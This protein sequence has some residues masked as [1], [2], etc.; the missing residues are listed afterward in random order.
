LK[1]GKLYAID[2]TNTSIVYSYT[3][4]AWS[5]G[6]RPCG[7]AIRNIGNTPR[8]FFSRNGFNTSTTGIY[9]IDL[10]PNGSFGSNQINEI[11]ISSQTDNDDPI[12]DIAFNKDFTE[13]L[14]AQKSN[15]D[16]NGGGG[17]IN[18][19]NHNSVNNIFRYAHTSTINKFK[20]N[21]SG[22]NSGNNW[23]NQNSNFKIGDYYHKSN[24]AGG[25]D[26]SDFEIN[27][28]KQTKCNATIY[29][30]TDL[31]FANPT[32]PS[33]PPT[34]NWTYCYGFTGFPNQH[35][36]GTHNG[37]NVDS[38]NS[39]T[40]WTKSV[41]GDIEIVDTTFN[42]EITPNCQCGDWGSIGFT[43]AGKTNKF[44]CSQGS[45][46]EMQANQ[47][48]ILTLNP[49]YNCNGSGTENCNAVIK[50]D[51]FY[52]DGTSQIGLTSFSGI[53]LEKCGRIRVVMRPTCNG[54]TC[55]PCEFFINVNCCNCKLDI[56][57]IIYFANATGTQDSIKLNCGKTYNNILDCFKNYTIKI[58]SPCG[59]TCEPDEVI[60]TITLPNGTVQTATGLSI[61]LSIGS[62]IGT[63]T[64]TIKVKCN[65]KWCADCVIKFNQTKSCQPVC[66]NCRD[67]VKA[68]FNKDKSNVIVN[69]HPL[70]SQLTAALQLDGGTDVYTQIRVSVIDFQVSSKEKTCLQCYNK[71]NNWGSILSGLISTSGFTAISTNYSGILTNN[72]N[73]NSREIVFNAATPVSVAAG[74]S[75]NLNINVPGVNPLSCCCIDIKLYLKVVYRNNKCEECIKIVPIG[76]TQCPKEKEGGTFTW[77]NGKATVLKLHTPS[78]LESKAAKFDELK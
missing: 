78:P 59:E 13:M 7:I 27:K 39:S 62:L 57:P 31:I 40:Y 8:L 29:A 45:A 1:D 25:V 72:P 21:P 43:L 73:N 65:G 56:A 77:E 32:V 5:S 26:Y 63:Y 22:T 9:S 6:D 4:T 71:P 60:T 52:P 75:L 34:S 30:T 17:Q 20:L 33:P 49:I 64:V 67:K 3:P 35:N 41:H 28:N 61:P 10:Y 46:Y 15:K 37:I 19:W 42:C 47:Y 11:S 74:T 36:A 24:A 69:Q 51:I 58:K 48:D 70:S 68:T 12:T 44:L 53:K 76:F 14:L 55:P 54:V 38:D 23:I 50:Y 16:H 2:V 18:T 66:D